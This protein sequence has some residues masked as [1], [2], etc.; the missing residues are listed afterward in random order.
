M[1]KISL[2]YLGTASFIIYTNLFYLTFGNVRCSVPSRRSGALLVLLLSQFN[3]LFSF[4]FLWTR[5]DLSLTKFGEVVCK[6]LEASTNKIDVFVPFFEEYMCNLCSFA[7]IWHVNDNKFV[8]GVLKAEKFRYN[9]VS[10]NVRGRIINWLFDMTESVFFWLA[11]V[12]QQELCVLSDTEHFSCVS[13]CGNLRHSSLM[14]HHRLYIVLI[15]Y[16]TST[17]WHNLTSLI[18]RDNL[19]KY[20]LLFY[21]YLLPNLKTSHLVLS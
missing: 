14:T 2:S 8:R 17:A 10:T 16:S 1:L 7:F 4:F 9:F 15:T 3:A 11:H 20:H 12:K 6:L 13:H 18:S 21:V 5:C 19:E